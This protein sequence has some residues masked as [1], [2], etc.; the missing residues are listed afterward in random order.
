[1]KLTHGEL[2]V[3]GESSYKLFDWHLK[4]CKNVL[5]H[6][7]AQ[8]VKVKLLAEYRA[9]LTTVTWHG[10]KWSCVVCVKLELVRGLWM[11]WK[12]HLYDS[13]AP[14][15]LDNTKHWEGRVQQ[16]HGSPRKWRVWILMW[17]CMLTFFW[18]ERKT[19]NCGW[20]IACYQIDG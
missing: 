5:L 15:T 13:E 3:T 17:V 14:L 4:H 8:I 2:W 7:P 9:M 6:K 16:T 10:V 18:F 19:R 20:K 1:M 11:E 12:R